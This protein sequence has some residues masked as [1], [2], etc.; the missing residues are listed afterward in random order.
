M[1]SNMLR[2]DHCLRFSPRFEGPF[3]II[4]LLKF[5]KFRLRHIADGNERVSHW[6]HLKLIKNDVDVS[7]LNPVTEDSVTNDPAP[8]QVDDEVRP[9]DSPYLLRSRVPKN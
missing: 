2:M 7:F 8:L 5:N 6:N 1:W 4:E 3:R 9:G